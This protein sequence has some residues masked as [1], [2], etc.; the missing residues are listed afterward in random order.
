MRGR[1]LMVTLPNL[2]FLSCL[3]APGCRLCK[4]TQWIFKTI[5]FCLVEQ[6]WGIRFSGFSSLWPYPDLL[7]KLL[8]ISTY[9]HLLVNFHKRCPLGPNDT[10]YWAN[11]PRVI[12]KSFLK[13]KRRFEQQCNDAAQRKHTQALQVFHLRM[14]SW[15]SINSILK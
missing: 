3:S 12:S 4:V 7:I 6:L 9:S 15:A 13:L 5:L 10:L 1:L 14:E 11:R 2:G 8:H